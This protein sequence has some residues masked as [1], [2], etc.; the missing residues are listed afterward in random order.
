MIFSFNLGKWLFD[1]FSQY[2]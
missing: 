2:W 1:F